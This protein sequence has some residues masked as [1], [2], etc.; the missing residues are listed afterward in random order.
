MAPNSS[1]EQ[2]YYFDKTV[3][4]RSTLF[5]QHAIIMDMLHNTSRDGG[6]TELYTVYTVEIALHC[7]NSSMYAYICILLGK[8]RT[9]LEWADKLLSKMWGDGVYGLMDGWTVMTT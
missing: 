2:T 9:L 3:F 8:D 5:L 6:S 7:S 4:L 1:E